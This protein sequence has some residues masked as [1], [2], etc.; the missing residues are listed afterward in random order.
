MPNYD[1]KVRFDVPTLNRARVSMDSDRRL[2]VDPID[3]SG[4]LNTVVSAA[5]KKQEAAAAQQREA[6]LSEYASKYD[7]IQVGLEQGIY[8]E[9]TADIMKRSLSEESRLRGVTIEE[10]T[11]LRKHYGA[12]IE[13]LSKTRQEMIVKEN[14]NV[15]QAR[16]ND[17]RTQFKSLQYANNEE[18]DN[19]IYLQDN[20]SQSQQYHQAILNDP[21]SSAAAKE[22]ARQA[23]DNA[24]T[25]EARM[26]NHLIMQD[27]YESIKDTKEV[28]QNFVHNLKE[29][30]AQGMIDRGMDYRKATMVAEGLVNNSQ[31][32][33]MES[34]NRYDREEG[35]KEA[36]NIA[37]NF[38]A[39]I[40][41]T[42]QRGNWELAK[43]HP[44]YAQV[45]SLP[46]GV[47]EKMP[48]KFFTDWA[49]NIVSYKG[50]VVGGQRESRG[51]Q[52]KSNEGLV[53]TV[54]A[55]NITLKNSSATKDN[56]FTTGGVA[57]D[58]S[59]S[60]IDTAVDKNNPSETD[61]KNVQNL[62][63]K[64][65]DPA[66]IAKLKE[67]AKSADPTTQKLAQAAENSRQ[68]F[69]AKANAVYFNANVTQPVK[70]MIQS[71]ANRLRTDSNGNIVTIDNRSFLQAVGDFFTN[72]TDRTVESVN[73]SIQGMSPEDRVA[74]FK[75]LGIQPLQPGEEVV[76]N[77]SLKDPVNLQRFFK[78]DSTISSEEMKE[79]DDAPRQQAIKALKDAI[80]R[81]EASSMNSDEAGRKYYGKKTQQQI[82]RAN[83]MIK[84]L[85]AFT[86]EEATT[87]SK[88][89]NKS[90]ISGASLVPD[91]PDEAMAQQMEQL[92]AEAA[93]ESYDAGADVD[94]LNKMITAGASGDIEDDNDQIALE[95]QMINE[96]I[97]TERD[98]R[99]LS[100]EASAKEI[101]ES[102]IEKFKERQK[103]ARANIKAAAEERKNRKK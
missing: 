24:I 102:L 86:G 47:I 72:D 50:Q 90:T 88:V 87:T 23:L 14:E 30:L 89:S 22:G 101:L 42:G 82:D 2:S 94:E 16:R 65:N 58:E 48:T 80:A 55:F 45:M 56:I 54:Q 70:E 75:Q 41:A 51:I 96:L 44:E 11:K 103:Q 18:I 9:T 34:K 27:Y 6:L 63:K 20:I 67:G 19:L 36:N 99:V 35:T 40:N 33:D 83:K 4:V 71:Q 8:D 13:S 49:D 43:Q 15:K 98:E 77:K 38:K 46:N 59:S 29:S 28:D 7:Q 57:A 95:N 74:M 39:S 84:D 69:N 92:R 68:D 5:G 62:Q 25:D 21:Y 85:E 3:I 73:N 1:A 66:Y 37:E 10:D 93:P 12:N 32:A 79:I 26:N 31:I 100:G 76:D 91:A 52:Y 81:V 17:I 64:L 53:N 61:I 78:D 97:K 60:F